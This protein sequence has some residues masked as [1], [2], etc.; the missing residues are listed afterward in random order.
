[1][2]SRRQEFLPYALPLIEDDDIEAVVDSL[3]SNWVTKGPKTAEFEKKFA[4]YIGVKHAIAFNSCTAGLHTA[5]IAAG[6]G[7]GD[8]VITTPMTF[9]A[10]ANVIIHAGATPVFVDIDP[11]TDRKSVV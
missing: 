6:I 4:D 9:A 11:V 10:S 3:K 7:E 5:L 1:M 8:E 2:S